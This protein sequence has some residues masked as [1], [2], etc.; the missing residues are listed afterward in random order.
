MHARAAIGAQGGEISDF[1][2]K[3]GFAKSGK[4]WCSLR[5][6]LP[7]GHSFTCSS[8]SKRR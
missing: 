8:P 7:T 2:L 1:T 6:F 4:L 5:E 3:T